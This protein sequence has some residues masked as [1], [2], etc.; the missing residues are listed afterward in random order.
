MT[1][2]RQG[3]S[4]LVCAWLS[5]RINSD[6]P[7][8][9]RSCSAKSTVKSPRPWLTISKRATYASRVS[10]ST[11]LPQP[12]QLKAARRGYPLPFT[13]QETQ[14]LRHRANDRELLGEFEVG[15]VP[16]AAFISCLRSPLLLFPSYFKLNVNT[17]NTDSMSLNTT[18]SFNIR[19]SY[20]L[21]FLIQLVFNMKNSI[22]RGLATVA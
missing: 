9:T 19:R 16:Q 21:S 18:I 10:A 6:L 5:T 8:I 11:E 15:R 12:N 17:Q 1:R 13:S 14:F 3:R 2:S 22:V 7:S 4:V 20:Y